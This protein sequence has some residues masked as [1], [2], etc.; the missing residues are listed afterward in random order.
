MTKEL[1]RKPL[2]SGWKTTVGWRIWCPTPCKD[3]IISRKHSFLHSFLVHFS[4]FSPLIVRGM[5]LAVQ[6]QISQSHCLNAGWWVALH[7]MK[8]V[9]R[10][11]RERE[12]QQQSREED[13]MC[14]IAW[15][16]HVLAYKEHA[17]GL[18]CEKIIN[19][20][21]FKTIREMERNFL[22]DYWWD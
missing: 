3:Y 2:D 1:H 18:W 11:E 12:L 14:L 13:Y 10:K 15:F 8:D 19:V 6:G 21:Y 4:F 20:F 16:K 9:R 7:G 5:L 17:L 22:I